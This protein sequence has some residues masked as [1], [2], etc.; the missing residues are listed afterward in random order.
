MEGYT[1]INC[2]EE[3]NISRLKEIPDAINFKQSDVVLALMVLHKERYSRKLI[4]EAINHNLYFLPHF[5]NKKHAR[6]KKAIYP[7]IG[8]LIETVRKY[9]RL[10]RNAYGWD[11]PNGNPVRDRLLEVGDYDPNSRNYVD[12]T[13][14]N[15]NKGRK[16]VY[17]YEMWEKM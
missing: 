12:K 9:E 13:L 17:A 14:K 2:Y 6:T 15:R 10:K 7:P 5:K 11:K 8:L 4:I 16:S 3:E 1:M